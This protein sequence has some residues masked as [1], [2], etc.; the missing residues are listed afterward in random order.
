M[1]RRIVIGYWLLVIG[2]VSDVLGAL[3]ESRYAIE[4]GG[5]QKNL[6]QSET[7]VRVRLPNPY[8]NL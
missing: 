1:I 2:F 6:K 3:C 8:Y 5:Y 7:S 4:V